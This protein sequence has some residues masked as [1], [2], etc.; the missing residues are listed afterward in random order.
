MGRIHKERI[1]GGARD[2]RRQAKAEED[3]EEHE[4]TRVQSNSYTTASP[5][6]SAPCQQSSQ[7]PACPEPRSPHHGGARLHTQPASDYQQGIGRSLPPPGH[8]KQS[9]RIY[10]YFTRNDSLAC[11]TYGCHECIPLCDT[12]RRPCRAIDIT[13]S[14]LVDVAGTVHACVVDV[15]RQRLGAR[16][17]VAMIQFFACELPAVGLT[18]FGGAADLT[19]I[20]QVRSDIPAPVKYRSKC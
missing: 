7:L 6:A 18:S 4:Q 16:L 1:T 9:V 14:L 20:G 2:E 17:S 15:F 10:S 12:T 11:R 5:V 3:T 19:A 13:G 8:H